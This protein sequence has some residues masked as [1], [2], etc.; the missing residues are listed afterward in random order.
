MAIT[1]TKRVCRHCES[2]FSFPTTDLNVRDPKFCSKTCSYTGRRAVVGS[3]DFTL[4]QIERFEAKFM[5]EPMSGCWLWFGAH[6][7]RGYGQVNLNKVREGAHRVAWRI[8]HGAIPDGLLVCHRCDNPAC[9]N[10]DHLF[11]GTYTDNMRDCSNKGRLKLTH[12]K[13]EQNSMAKLT[14]PLVKQIRAGGSLNYWNQ[15]TGVSP[16]SI[17]N[18]RSGKTWRHV[19]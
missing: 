14:A 5:P 12:H 2:E 13:G 19:Q 17:A 7:S 4:K 16:T 3:R 6:D 9:V 1:M 11:L 15:I 10:P 18:A 8:Y